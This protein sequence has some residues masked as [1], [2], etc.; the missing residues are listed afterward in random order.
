MSRR[1]I[2]MVLAAVGAVLVFL[3]AAADA[4]GISSES[5]EGWGTRQTIGVAVGVLVFLAGAGLVY[6][7]RKSV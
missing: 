7:N 4:I 2:G 1:I 3:A 5:S 6:L